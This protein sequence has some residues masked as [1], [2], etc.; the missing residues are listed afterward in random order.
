MALSKWDLVAV[1][2]NLFQAMVDRIRF[3]FPL[4]GFAPVLALSGGTGFGLDR[5][6]AKVVEL[7]RQLVHTVP[8]AKL[9]QALARWAQ[10]YVPTVRGR[11]VRVQYAT[12]TS[13]N[14]LRFVCFV[15]HARGA[16]AAYRRFL[17]NR[18]RSELGFPE[19]PVT[20]E[21]RE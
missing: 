21:F 4:L 2:S 13:A 18:M 7:H 15:N 14:P 3:Q 8:T 19:V 9:N 5:V 1:E 12:Q 16:G 11:E 20:V 6:L 17:E 10:E